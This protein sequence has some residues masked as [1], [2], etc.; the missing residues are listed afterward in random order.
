MSIDARGFSLELGFEPSRRLSIGF[1]R[2][3]LV[4]AGLGIE[5]A[6]VAARVHAERL[7]GLA[8]VNAA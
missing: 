3:G 4:L 7:K 6:D 5:K 8:V 1:H 2:E